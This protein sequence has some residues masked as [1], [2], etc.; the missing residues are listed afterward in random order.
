MYR[1]YTIKKPSAGC[2]LLNNWKQLAIVV[3]DYNPA[4]G[5][6]GQVLNAENIF[7]DSSL[8]SWP[9]LALEIEILEKKWQPV[10]VSENLITGD[11][12]Q[13]LPQSMAQSPWELILLLLLSP[14]IHE[15][16]LETFFD[17]GLSP[18]K[19]LMS[20]IRLLRQIRA[21][22]G[23]WDSIPANLQI[24]ENDIYL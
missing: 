9:P 4:T 3:T 6:K 13:Y 19:G 18:I 8:I 5:A 16:E 10:C 7:S 20:Y 14:Q 24:T 22:S 1:A 17:T 15:Q 21:R 23:I 11:V 2:V 12:L